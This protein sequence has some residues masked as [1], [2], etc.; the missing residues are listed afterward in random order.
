[1]GHLSN[2][3][4][5]WRDTAHRLIFERQDKSAVAPL[6]DVLQHNPAPLARL[7]ALWSLHGLQ[8]LRD[9]DLLRALSDDSSGVREHAVKLSELRLDKN[10]AL[11]DR[12]R[13]LAADPDPRVRFQ[14]AFSL[15]ESQ[16][17]GATET[18]ARL[19]ATD[20]DDA[21]LRTAILSSCGDRPGSVL[22]KILD[23]SRAEL[24]SARAPIRQLA[25]VVGGRQQQSELDQFASMLV[26]VSRQPDSR[27][28]L[29]ELVIGFGDGLKHAGKSM[30]LAL[31]GS[32]ASVLLQNVL[33]AA[34]FAAADESLPSADRVQAVQLMSFSEFDAVAE[35]LA[36]LLDT[37]QPH[38]VQ[39]AAVKAIAGFDNA[40]VAPLL[41]AAWSS[42]TPPVRTEIVEALLTRN[43]RVSWLLDSIESG[44]IAP[45]YVSAARRANLMRSTN[46][47]V[48]DRALALFQPQS[49]AARREVIAR[50][51]AALGRNANGQLGERVYDRECKSCH[52]LRDK[53]EEVGPDLASVLHHA[54]QQLLANI[55]DPN[56]EV[57]PN[58][59]EYVVALDDGRVL[60]GII[61]SETATAIV[62]RRAENVQ[63]TVLRKSVAEI[64]SSG[65]SLMPEG[66]DSRISV[67][68]MA[69]LIAFLK[70]SQGSQ[71]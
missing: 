1:V 21:W 24:R 67:Q 50:Y 54:P 25:Q 39:L 62:L 64:R 70:G 55:L 40:G 9:A 14:L 41:L 5:W 7:H 71:H 6:R 23:E 29:N 22:A 37:R 8:E 17:T 30:R 20:T 46:A 11:L 59:I 10:P 3:N 69:D 19:A 13:A 60:T 15:G 44:T 18:L 35:P 53:G 52:R 38:A 26:A 58:Y 33:Q 2:P 27:A 12:V 57:S 48:R 61:A 49:S 63:E 47:V 65:K 32:E 31:A 68:E 34:H 45:A 4:G 28:C 51:D 42:C 43:D 16:S 36:K 56:R 66:L